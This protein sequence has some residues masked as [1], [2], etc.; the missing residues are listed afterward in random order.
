VISGTG[1][2]QG[3]IMTFSWMLNK[4]RDL[5]NPLLWSV[6]SAQVFAPEMIA[7]ASDDPNVVER[8]RH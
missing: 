6:I 1:Q 4:I 5:P 7:R 3:I 2:L 8:S